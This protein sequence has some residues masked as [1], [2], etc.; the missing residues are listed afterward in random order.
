MCRSL[1]LDMDWNPVMPVMVKFSDFG[2]HE[3]KKQIKR[4]KTRL[5]ADL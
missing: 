2:N 1:H 5:H 4:R 3:E